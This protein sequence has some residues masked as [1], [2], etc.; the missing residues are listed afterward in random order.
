MAIFLVY[1]S[2]PNG[3]E[4]EVHLGFEDLQDGS[5]ATLVLLRLHLVLVARLNLATCESTLWIS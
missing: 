4:K 5:G 1:S 3:L 2:I